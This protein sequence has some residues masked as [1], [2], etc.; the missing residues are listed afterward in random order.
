MHAINGISSQ[1]LSA[2]SEI[3]RNLQGRQKTLQSWPSSNKLTTTEQFY[4]LQSINARA[5]FTPSYLQP[6]NLAEAITFGVLLVLLC[7]CLTD[8]IER[9]FPAFTERM[10]LYY[11]MMSLIQHWALGVCLVKLSN[12]QQ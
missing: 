4:I 11:C 7:L 9:P 8:C 12:I 2:L 6:L 1:L 5:C 3:E 10:E